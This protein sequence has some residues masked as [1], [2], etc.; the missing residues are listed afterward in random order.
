VIDWTVVAIGLDTGHVLFYGDNGSPIHSQIWHNE[1]VTNLKAQSG[2]HINEEV[3]VS[4]P[5]CVCMVQGDRI[6]MKFFGRKILRLLFF[7]RQLIN[8]IFLSHISIY[9]HMYE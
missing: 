9:V 2:K 8:N 3:Y 1:S 5:S 4:Y 6:A 7:P